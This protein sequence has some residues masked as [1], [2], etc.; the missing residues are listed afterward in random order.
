MEFTLPPRLVTVATIFGLT[1]TSASWGS[2]A[3]YPSSPAP[4]R[5]MVAT[6]VC[7]S[8]FLSEMDFP[9]HHVG[10][11]G[12][13]PPLTISAH[14]ASSQCCRF[15]GMEPSFLATVNIC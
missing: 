12:P 10:Q 13:K 8:Y 15:T 7:H 1:V 4:G 9:P 5:P 2:G 3:N 14:S 11:A 6:M